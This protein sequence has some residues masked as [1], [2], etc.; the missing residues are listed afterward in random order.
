LLAGGEETLVA[1]AAPTAAALDWP[2]FRGPGRDGTVP[3]VRI[4]T[5]WSTAPPT[6]QWRRPVGPGWSSFAVLGNLFY[7]QEQRGDEEIVAA[8]DIAT[9][10][11]VW[12]HRDAARFY[13]AQGGAGPRG[14]PAVHDG[15]VYALGATGILNALDAADGALVWSRDATADTGAEIP[16]WGISSSP[17]VVDDTLIVAA[18][19]TLAGYDFATGEVRWTGKARGVGYSSPH[20]TTIDGVMQVLQ[21]SSTGLTSVAPADGTLLWEHAWE[22][23][24]MVQP[25]RTTDGDLLFTAGVEQGM[26]RLAVALGSGG[27]TVEERWTTQRL[28]PYFN[29]F[30]V[31]ERHAY[32]FDKAILSCIDLETGERTWKGGRYGYGQ[33]VLLPDQD[34][35]LVLSER[36]QL[37]LVQASP[38]GF[39]EVAQMDALDGKTWN[40]PVL[41]GNLL[42]VR[43]DREMAAFRL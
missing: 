5:D 35:L 2:G 23:F 38:E 42:L 31:H 41:V 28:K 7:T 32:G 3:G 27:W 20:L 29:D 19:G 8:H 6:E 17:L 4:A 14:T 37:A 24:P 40:H 39:H 21:P 16:Y 30:V 34:L 25:A 36:G 33:M 9:G 12:R 22:G 15:R 18:S 11:P 43:N 10:Q 13:E 26:R 1:P